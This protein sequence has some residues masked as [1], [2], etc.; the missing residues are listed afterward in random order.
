MI[1][2]A[3]YPAVGILT[4]DIEQTEDGVILSDGLEPVTHTYNLDH[5]C[6][7]FLQVTGRINFQQR[8]FRGDLL[9]LGGL[10]T[11]FSFQFSCNLLASVEIVFVGYAGTVSPYPQ[12]HD[13]HMVPV[14]VRMLIYHVR[15]IAEAHFIHVLPRYLRELRVCQHIVRMRIQGD[16]HH[17]SLCLCCGGHPLHK[18]GEGAFDVNRTRTVIIDSVCVEQ[19]AFLFV[20]LLCIV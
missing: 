3:I 20:D 9:A 18:I 4:P 5:R 16:M 19:P 13:V 10:Q 1:L 11:V 6:N 14:D 12:C 17:R 7:L 8:S 15:H 2:T